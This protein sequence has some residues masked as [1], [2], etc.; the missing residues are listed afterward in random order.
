MQRHY[1][2]L[3]EEG[4]ELASDIG[5]LVFTGTTDD[6]E[7][8]ATLSRLGFHE[9]ERAAET[10]R[11]WHFGRRAAITSQRAREVLTEF[12]PA[13]LAALGGTPDPDAAL[14]ALDRAFGRMPAVVELLTIL[15]SHDRLR[16]LFADLLGTAPR[17]ADTVAQSPHVLDALIDPAFVDPVSDEKGIEEQVRQ[18]IGQ[19][20]RSRRVSRP[21]PRCGAPDALRHRRTSAL[22][23]PALRRAQARLMRPSRAPIVRASL[24]GSAPRIFEVDH[25]VVPGAE[26]AILG[27]GRLGSREL[28]AGSDLDLVVIYDF[29]EN[30]REST[31][32]RKLDVVVYY[33]RLTQRLVAALTVPTRR[34]LLYEVDLRLRPQGGKGPVAS[35]FRGFVQYQTS[36]AELWEHMALTRARV[37]AGD[38]AIR[39]DASRQPSRTSSPRR[40]MPA[41]V[42]KQVRTCAN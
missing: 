23:H 10:I 7:T 5:N 37:I 3:F 9:P 11:G 39:R 36:E 32:P 16:L 2:L 20:A 26:I 27:L 13:L 18:I 21:R 42:F 28:T 29:D 25:G 33:T 4:P 38:D 41:T 1:A 24:R 14:A 12:V 22:R 15:Q 19:P 31:G 8:L 17:L 40:A 6:P 34:G 35:Q 30:N